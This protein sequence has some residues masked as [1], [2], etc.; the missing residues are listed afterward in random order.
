MKKSLAVIIMLLSIFVFTFVGCTPNSYGE[1]LG[2]MQELKEFLQKKEINLMYPT[3]LPNESYD[4]LKQN[5]IANYDG[6][7]KQYDGYKIYHFTSPFNISVCGFNFVSDTLIT[8]DTARLTKKGDI[9]SNSYKIEIFTGE[10]Y[11]KSLFVIGKIIIDNSQYE[12][13]VVGN[14]EKIDGKFINQI[15]ENNPLYGQ[16][17]DMVIALVNSLM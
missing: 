8:D 17:I 6:D 15:F 13:R 11:E 1:N 4:K 12:V 7:K 16:A 3:S 10:G 14:K 2:G 9:E 5:F